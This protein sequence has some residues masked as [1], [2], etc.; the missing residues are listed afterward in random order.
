MAAPIAGVSGVLGRITAIETRFAPT[1]PDGHAVPTIESAIP[2]DPFGVAYQ[3][4]VE[5]AARAAPV[6][7]PAA[8]A[9][10]W[11]AVPQS[12]GAGGAASSGPTAAQT[13]AAIVG[14]AGAPGTRPVGGYGP[15]P[16]PGELAAYGNGQVPSVALA[17]FG[18]RGHRLAAP[19]AAAWGNLVA[20]AAADGIELLITD[21]Y[22]PYDEQVSLAA[23]KG[24]TSQGGLA[25]VPGTSNHGW[26]LAVDAD[27][28]DPATLDWLRTNGPRFGWVEAVPREPWHW[29]FR[30]HQV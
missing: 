6:A 26:G 14:L 1:R 16:V 19:A 23:R 18:Q 8:P 17:P 21:S 12:L 28:T 4:A 15:M 2:F 22:R 11:S 9:A 24:L 5:A 3:D 7:A 29:E 27:V 20:A 13:A 25:A 10:A 30:P